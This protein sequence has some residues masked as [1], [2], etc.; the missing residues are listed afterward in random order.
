VERRNALITATVLSGAV[1]AASAAIG[2][3]VGLLSSGADEN[4]V[5]DL[6]VDDLGGAD[7]STSTSTS[8]P[9]T[10]V[11]DEYVTDPAATGPQAPSAGGWSA[12]NPPGASE[13][14]SSSGPDG[15]SSSSN[16]P[17]ISPAPAFRDDH[18]EDDHDDEHE[19]EHEYEGH[20]DD[21]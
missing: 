13:P 4:P 18:R 5:G 12:V 3:N 17:Q 6:Q 1:F 16:E 9:V 2:L 15:A 10:V 14:S 7:A 19:Y 21:D 11:V 20:D 8:A